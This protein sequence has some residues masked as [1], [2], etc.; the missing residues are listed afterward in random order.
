M[1]VVNDIEDLCFE[2]LKTMSSEDAPSNSNKVVSVDIVCHSNDSDFETSEQSFSDQD[3]PCCTDDDVDSDHGKETSPVT[4]LQKDNPVFSNVTVFEDEANATVTLEEIDTGVDMFDSLRKVRKTPGEQTRHKLLSQLSTE[5]EDGYVRMDSV[6]RSTTFPTTTDTDATPTTT[7]ATDVTDQVP[8][9]HDVVDAV[10]DSDPSFAFDDKYFSQILV[11]GLPA[12]VSKNALKMVLDQTG[13]GLNVQQV[14]INGRQA[15]VTFENPNDLLKILQGEYGTKGLVLYDSKL[16]LSRYIPPL[17]EPLKWFVT[18]LPEYIDRGYLDDILTDTS[19]NEIK[20]NAQGQAIVG[21]GKYSE[22]KLIERKLRKLSE[23]VRPVEEIFH[24]MVSGYPDFKTAR[25]IFRAY[26]EGLVDSEGS[27]AVVQ[28]VLCH[29]R[30]ED[31]YVVSFVDR[32]DAHRVA[33]QPKHVINGQE[34]EVTLYYPCMDLEPAAMILYPEPIVIDQVDNC[35]LIYIKGTQNIR[36]STEVALGKNF[37]EVRWKTPI[38]GTVELVCNAKPIDP[39][40]K[41]KIMQFQNK[42]KND[43]IRLTNSIRVIDGIH[44]AKEVKEKF[45]AQLCDMMENIRGVAIHFNAD[46]SLTVTGGDKMA[47]TLAEKI[48]NIIDDLETNYTKTYKKLTKTKTITYA[49][50]MLTNVKKFETTVSRLGARV[51]CKEK[52]HNMAEFTFC[53]G[54]TA[55]DKSIMALNKKIGSFVKLPVEGLT[56]IEQELLL[57]SSVQQY[58]NG[59]ISAAHNHAV[60]SATKIGT[61]TLLGITKQDIDCATKIIRQSVRVIGPI[62]TDVKMDPECLKYLS[63]L[64]EHYSDA[65][66]VKSDNVR[67]VL[68]ACTDEL[69]RSLEPA[70]KS[71]FDSR[72][73]VR[74]IY[75]CGKGLM[76]FLQQYKSA[77]FADLKKCCEKENDVATD[78]VATPDINGFRLKGRKGDVNEVIK[79]LN[80]WTTSVV[81]STL[82]FSRSEE[83]EFFLS[84][85]GAE[86]LA[87]VA[88]SHRA[89]IQVKEVISLSEPVERAKFSVGSAS[90]YIHEGNL[91][92]QPCGAIVHFTDTKLRFDSLIGKAI[93]RG[94]GIDI[95]KECENYVSKHGDLPDGGM[96]VST[97]GKL[98]CSGIIHVAITRPNDATEERENVRRLTTTFISCFNT[99]GQRNF[100]SLA[101]SPKGLQD[102]TSMKTVIEALGTALRNGHTLQEIFLVDLNIE[103]LSE[104]LKEM[105]SNRQY[106]M[107][108][109]NVNEDDLLKNQWMDILPKSQQ[110]EEEDQFPSQLKLQII[111]GELAKQ[112]ADIYVNSSNEALQLDLGA[113]SKSLVEAAG[114]VIQ[115]ECKHNYQNRMSVGS[116]AVTS[117]GIMQCKNI[118]HAVLMPWDNGQGKAEHFLK[119]IVERALMQADKKKASTI[120]FPALGTGNNNFPPNEAAR[121]MLQTI[122]DYEKTT[123]LRHLQTVKI[124]VYHPELAKEF[125]EQIKQINDVSVEKPDRSIRPTTQFF[126][127][128]SVADVW[129]Y[130]M[131]FDDVI[132]VALTQGDIVEE[133]TD[134]IV[135]SLGKNLCLDHGQVSQSIKKAAG[136]SIQQEF[137]TKKCRQSLEQNALVVTRGEM[138]W[139]HAII[140]AR[141]RSSRAKIE[142]S[143]LSCLQEASKLQLSSIAFPALGTGGKGC[144]PELVAEA[145]L[146]AFQKFAESH[147]KDGRH[148]VRLAKVVIYDKVV[149]RKFLSVFMNASTNSES[150]LHLHIYAES[151][152][153]ISRIKDKIQTYTKCSSR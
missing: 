129:P 31:C 48:N 83:K 79:K 134:A 82:P 84:P 3:N 40:V 100:F 126:T 37:C 139:C 15:V 119:L 21:F 52:E 89:V 69:F 153:Q 114:T 151:R 10:G 142:H 57:V 145:M 74:E 19:V 103:V 127:Q 70:V 20:M 1:K 11:T 143:V 87:A 9:D 104:I 12:G 4:S 24:I 120:A 67:Q 85:E 26:F 50:M 109:A 91:T 68:I 86:V 56:P 66:V 23:D 128:S 14:E 121:I 102:L 73:L 63:E 117:G 30:K 36:R 59:T 76:D 130:Y 135:N 90:I 58:V 35:V 108:Y 8:D 34:V 77:E 110:A 25:Q 138:L 136:S 147:G 133:K 113:I 137:E 141:A 95:R 148:S 78:I 132:M 72:R 107:S 60:V 93:V 152:E 124:V 44:F 106:R 54:K 112:R 111:V 49:E 94:G 17:T 122:L 55:V 62:L 98:P 45:S 118:F 81:F 88:S 29:P 51:T 33:L 61:L 27:M 80:K 96:F 140:H 101:M 116:V 46:D 18:S 146:S 39:N 149:A 105:K 43:F 65:V 53:G 47:V 42:A 38:Q 97:A 22:R 41:K 71:F 5:L 64:S 75:D 92:L 28:Q 13:L 2:I 115:E 144:K 123:S 6:W 7:L 125:R 150:C 32:K 16:T 131:T 99:A